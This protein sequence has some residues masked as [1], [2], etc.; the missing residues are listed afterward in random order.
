MGGIVMERDGCIEA[1]VLHEGSSGCTRAPHCCRR[2]MTRLCTGGV[3]ST[4]AMICW[5]YGLFNVTDLGEQGVFFLPS[6]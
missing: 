4:I 6:A 1:F 3:C 5:S 2:T